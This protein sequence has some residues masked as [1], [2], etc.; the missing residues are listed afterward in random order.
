MRLE[1][2]I[3]QKSFKDEF[4]KLAV[5]LQFTAAHYR[6]EFRGRLKPYEISPEQFNILRI[7]RGQHP[8]AASAKLVAERMIDRS[9]NVSRLVEKLRVKGHVNRTACDEDRRSVDLEITGQGLEVLARLAEDM[10]TTNMSLADHLTN[11]EAKQ[12]NDLLDKVRG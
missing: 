2:E 9:S 1:D 7:L 5:N 6:N 11:A 3:V 10:E 12:L 8:G 4:H